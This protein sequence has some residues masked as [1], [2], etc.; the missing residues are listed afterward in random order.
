MNAAKKKLWIGSA[1]A[2]GLLLY[3]AFLLLPGQLFKEPYSTVLE[4]RTGDLLGASIADDGQWRFPRID[5]I[6]DK[7]RIAAIQFED[8]RF[9][10]H[11][12]VDVL[13][14]GRAFRENVRAGRVVSGGSTLTMQVIKLSRKGQPRTYLEKFLE[15]L[16]ATRLELRFSKEEIFSLYAAHA[17]FGGNVVGLEAACWRYF[18]RRPQSLSWAEA[19][20]L[21]VLPNNPSLLRPGRNQDKLKARRNFLLQKLARAGYLDETALSLAMQEPIPQQPLPLPRLAPHLLDRAMQEGLSQCRV[22]SSLE[23]TLQQRTVDIVDR[24]YLRL[25]SNQIH[26]AAVVVLDLTSGKTLA[27]VGNTHS[28]SSNQEQVDVIRARRSTGSI[29]KPFLYAGL[30]DDGNWLSRTLMP[31]V[32]TFI[33]GFAPKNYSHEYD[34]AVP[35]N[36]ALMRS[37]NI[38]FVHALRDYRYEKFYHLL[39]KTGFT[40]FD[41]PADHYGLSL[42]LGGAEATLWEVVTAYGAMAHRLN[43]HASIPLVRRPAANPVFSSSYLADSSAHET[44]FTPVASAAAIWETVEALKELS[45]PGEETGWKYFSSSK[46]IAWKTGTSFGFRDGWAVGVTPRYV[47]GVWTGNADGEGRPGLVGSETAAPIL[48]EVFALLPGHDWFRQPLDEMDFVATCRQSGQ[49]FSPYCTQADSTWITHAGLSSGL[50]RYHKPVHLTPDQ[51]FRAHASCTPATELITVNRFVLPPVQEYY[52]KQRNL[53]YKALP[54]YRSGCLDPSS[55][56][57]MDLIYPRPNSRLYLPRELDGTNGMA[58]FEAT[59][60]SPKAQIFWHLDGRYIGSTSLVHRLVLAPT[61]GRHT[62]SLV[63]E[64]GQYL[65]RTF[66]VLSE[67]RSR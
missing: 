59:H 50:C 45:R 55:V 65:T 6:P 3:Y 26:N 7:Y 25:K 36:E 38:P 30:L 53:S 14:L 5:S 1:L 61:R 28:G 12:G 32:P 41:K 20:L 34:G 57:A 52:Y 64:S 46:P 40:T 43:Q 29:L 44:S 67:N 54:P 15:V 10:Q 39:Q 11:I 22:V 18:G 8:R 16:M 33:N 35:L 9:E 66:D 56:A 4:D 60:R 21:A 47:V 19:A 51:R 58:V 62:L 13:A 48:F 27:Y 42:V 37:L 49:R 23:T 24:H 31:D 17:P 2:G 63:D